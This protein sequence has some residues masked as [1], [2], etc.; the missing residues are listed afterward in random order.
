[1]DLAEVASQAAAGEV[2]YVGVGH[3]S[4]DSEASDLSELD[5]SNAQPWN[6]SDGLR[7]RARNTQ[8]A[9][10]STFVS[11][12]GGAG[13]SVGG[14]GGG[15]AA[16]GNHDVEDAAGASAVAQRRAEVVL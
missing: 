6:E 8:A 7:E 11:A 12:A 14:G 2:D 15:G 1:M 4:S 9:G 5:G 16:D 3:E 10:A 13:G